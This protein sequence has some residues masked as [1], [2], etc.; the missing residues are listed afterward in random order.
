MA[1]I[2]IEKKKKPIWPW[3][4][5]LLI[6]AAIIIWIWADSGD[7]EEIEDNVVT[8]E[9]VIE[10]EEEPMAAENEDN[11]QAPAAVSDYV[12]WV[13]KEG[14]NMGLPHE[15]THKGITNFADALE[16][17]AEEMPD[18]PEVNEQLQK[19]RQQ[20]D[21]LKKEKESTKHADIIRKAFISGSNVINEFKNM[22]NSG[23]DQQV[24]D[25]MSTA[26]NVK[27]DEL[28]TN[29]AKAV[30]NFFSQSADILDRMAQNIQS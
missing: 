2:K 4:I 18:S 25:L 16:A 10:E 7:T 11:M 22:G 17:M 30:N 24:Q 5:A 14:G 13:E 20:A 6:I 3:I 8:D 12:A 9:Q 19:L 15:Y 28:A 26:K 23:M 29:Q 1:E 27:A 21:Q